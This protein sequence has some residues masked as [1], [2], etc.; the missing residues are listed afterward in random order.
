MSAELKVTVSNVKYEILDEN[1]AKLKT[2]YVEVRNGLSH[3]VTLT[4]KYYIYDIESSSFERITPKKPYVE[5][6]TIKSNGILR[7]TVEVDK[8]LFNFDLEKTLKVEVVDED[9]DITETIIVKV[10]VD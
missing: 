10:N 9:G 2:F 8:Y 1:K 4:L 6:G 5:L 7:K 3:P